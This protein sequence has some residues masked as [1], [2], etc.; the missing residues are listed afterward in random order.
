M[1]LAPATSEGNPSEEENPLE[2]ALPLAVRM[3]PRRDRKLARL[4]GEG[5]LR[6]LRRGEVVYRRGD[7][8]A[9]LFHVEE[10]YVCL[11]VPFDDGRGERAVD[12]AGPGDLF[13]AEALLPARTRLYGACAGE[14]TRLR[15]AKGEEA[16]RIVRGSRRTFE[17]LLENL[18]R[19]LAEARTVAPGSA[20][21]PTSRRLADVVLALCERFG[22]PHE[23]N[24]E[25]FVSHWIPH[26]V[27][28][29]LTGAHR[30][31]V[32]TLLNDWSYRGLLRHDRRSL[33]LLR[34]KGAL[35]EA[36]DA[37]D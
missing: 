19:E 24:G 1:I 9:H 23:G 11:T 6:E 35:L 28:A 29:E 8:S 27:L 33:V 37:P 16:A 10:G 2:G 15:E 22:A 5:P 32:T 12:L 3:D 34:G 13:G 31:T 14:R 36:S 7:P 25:V 18:E 4:L 20:S 26:R 17:A 30:S 21:P